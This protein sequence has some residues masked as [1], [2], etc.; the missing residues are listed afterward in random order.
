MAVF[1]LRNVSDA[2]LEIYF[3][4]KTSHFCEK[5]WYKVRYVCHNCA[6]TFQNNCIV[7]RSFFFSVKQR[8]LVK[9]H[10]GI[11]SYSEQIISGITFLQP[12]TLFDN[13][14][15]P[16]T[17][18]FLKFKRINIFQKP[19]KQLQLSKTWYTNEKIFLLEKRIKL[20]TFVDL[21][22]Y[23]IKV[24]NFVKV[25]KHFETEVLILVSF[26]VCIISEKTFFCKGR[27][28]GAIKKAFFTCAMIFYSCTCNKRM[29][30]MQ[31]FPLLPNYVNQS[32]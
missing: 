17:Y 8:T 22:V 20:P 27:D 3:V 18:S 26:L 10:K 16:G 4:L 12:S 21:L 25:A 15:V 28:N 6:L 1:F 24:R 9:L 23:L 13:Q 30:V 11:L 5:T 2:K 31:D 19:V 32:V 29:C 7:L 14:K